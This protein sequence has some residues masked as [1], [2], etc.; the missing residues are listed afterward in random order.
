M[1]SSESLCAPLPNIPT[2]PSVPTIPALASHPSSS[3]PSIITSSINVIYAEEGLCNSQRALEY[4][5]DGASYQDDTA[6]HGPGYQG[7]TT[8][9]DPGYHD[10]CSSDEEGLQ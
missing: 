1:H 9:H 2:A 10:Y 5:D 8:R 4:Q 3:V 6:R 7:D